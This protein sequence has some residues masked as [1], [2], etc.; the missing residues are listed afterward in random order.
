MNGISKGDFIGGA[1]AKYMEKKITPL[2]DYLFL[3]FICLF[4]IF[5]RYKCFINSPDSFREITIA[6][7]NN[8]I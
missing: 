5:I 6:Y 8:N 2:V 7:T 1:I 4:I 3:I